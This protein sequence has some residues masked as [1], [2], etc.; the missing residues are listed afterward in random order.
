M[1]TAEQPPTAR[2]R[3]QSSFASGASQPEEFAIEP[4]MTARDLATLV[5]ARHG[6]AARDPSL[7]YFTLDPGGG[8]GG[9]LPD[10]AKLLPQLLLSRNKKS[11]NGGKPSLLVMHMRSGGL[12]KIH[13]AACLMPGGYCKS[14]FV[15]R[16]T[17][18]GEVLQLLL[19]S[20]GA[21]AA[22]QSAEFVLTERDAEGRELRQ[23]DPD[24]CPLVIQQARKDLE[25]HLKRTGR[26]GEP[27][28]QQ[29]VQ[30]PKP[31]TPQQ[32]PPSQKPPEQKGGGGGSETL[33]RLRDSFRDL[34]RLRAE[35]RELYERALLTRPTEPAEAAAASDLRARLRKGGG[36]GLE[37]SGFE[38]L[39]RRR[40]AARRLQRLEGTEAPM[41]A[42]EAPR[43]A[44]YAEVAPAKR[45]A[46]A[47]EA[48]DRSTASAATSFRRQ[49]TADSSN[50]RSSVRSVRSARSEVAQRRV[51]AARQSSPPTTPTNNVPTTPTTPLTPTTPTSATGAARRQ[52]PRLPAAG[53]DDLMARRARAELAA[54]RQLTGTK[55]DF[56]CQAALVEQEFEATDSS[57]W[58]PTLMELLSVCRLICR[59]L[60]RRSFTH[61]WGI[62]CY[63]AQLRLPAAEGAKDAS[64]AA[65]AISGPVGRSPAIGIVNGDSG[66]FGGVF[67]ANPRLLER[68]RRLTAID[69]VAE[70]GA[71]GG[72]DSGLRSGDLLVEVNG[73]SVL[74]ASPDDIERMLERHW[75]LHLLVARPRTSR[76]S[77]ESDADSLDDESLAAATLAAAGPTSS[78][79]SSIADSA[80]SESAGGLRLQLRRLRLRCQELAE[81]ASGFERQTEQLRSLLA[82]RARVSVLDQS[83]VTAGGRR[84]LPATRQPAG[85]T[86]VTA[87]PASRASFRVI[88]EQQRP[89]VGEITST[90]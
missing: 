40:G 30:S 44:Y 25:I 7:Y 29:P 19:A 62:H 15:S 39:T 1:P 26:T 33:A 34:Q 67:R 72:A 57:R 11:S 65:D 49:T 80:N 77:R 64:D 2:V 51:I 90:V 74:T 73:V 14:L 37:R 20:Y 38:S 3:V 41:S 58:R 68:L 83:G 66:G 8:G 46:E 71:A 36:S 69:S 13:D 27:A 81:R 88:R 31:P 85:D 32:H 78:T 52:L 56:Q 53:P 63:T 6:M 24:D 89:T 45:S 75:T 43:S 48:V 35:N 23:L 9:G 87:S 12:V 17:T 4:S 50:A 70:D 16:R 84:Q 82:Q 18:A 59:R 28:A 47:E 54:Q 42:R 60:H 5:L 79:P 55:R 86:A 76:R 21:K 22:S 61:G 10:D